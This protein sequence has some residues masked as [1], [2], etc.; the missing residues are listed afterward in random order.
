MTLSFGDM[1]RK[2]AIFAID[3]LYDKNCLFSSST[4]LKRRHFERSEKS[5]YVF[6]PLL[7][8]NT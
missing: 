2:K 8:A 4:T 6:I 5:N 7:T 1:G 3:S